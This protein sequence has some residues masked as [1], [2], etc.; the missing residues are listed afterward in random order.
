MT[1][2][3]AATMPND[4]LPSGGRNG[5]PDGMGSCHVAGNVIGTTV[6][7]SAFMVQVETKTTL[8]RD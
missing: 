8:T 7:R 4:N 5:N 6:S 1:I 3:S 2:R